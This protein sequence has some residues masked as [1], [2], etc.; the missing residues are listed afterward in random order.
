M[1]TTETLHTSSTLLV[2][3]DDDGSAFGDLYIDDGESIDP[4]Q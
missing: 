4:K 2:A 3:L 1:T